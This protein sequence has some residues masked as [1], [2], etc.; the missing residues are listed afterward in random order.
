M[1]G[2]RQAAEAVIASPEETHMLGWARSSVA[3]LIY[4]ALGDMD[5]FFDRMRKAAQ[6]HTLRATDL[7]YSPL[8]AKARADPRMGEVFAVSGMQWKPKS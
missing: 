1:K 5:T 8:F 7:M 6:E 2:D 3:D 4:F